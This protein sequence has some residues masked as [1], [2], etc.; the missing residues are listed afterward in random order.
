MIKY[1]RSQPKRSG[2]KT[3][4]H[5]V[6]KILPTCHLMH[7]APKQPPYNLVQEAH[8]QAPEYS[9]FYQ[10]Q[11]DPEKNNAQRISSSIALLITNIIKDKSYEPSHRNT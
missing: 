8:V 2:K 9:W 11:E 3:E 7:L 4:H 5:K 6:H 1:F 10:F